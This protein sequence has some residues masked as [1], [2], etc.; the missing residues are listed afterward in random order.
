MKHRMASPLPDGRHDR[1]T[2]AT[3]TSSAS[4]SSRPCATTVA[5]RASARSSPRV[6]IIHA[7]C[8]FCRLRS[9]HLTTTPHF[10]FP[11][12]HSFV[13]NRLP[14]R[15]ARRLPG[16]RGAG[17]GAH[18]RRPRGGDRGHG[19]ALHRPRR[20]QGGLLGLDGLGLKLARRMRV[21]R[22]GAD[23]VVFFHHPSAVTVTALAGDDRGAGPPGHVRQGGEQVRLLQAPPTLHARVHG[24]QG[25]Q[26]QQ[27]QQ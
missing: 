26:A 27:Q 22:T 15:P 24:P 1:W 12:S 3:S 21:H 11:P 10:L 23:A 2:L 17:D 9:C 14:G 16:V 8:L 6:R 19:E 5:S 13:R 4:R 18:E 25:G 7:P 20:G